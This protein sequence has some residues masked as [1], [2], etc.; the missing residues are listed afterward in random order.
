M[1]IIYI[2]IMALASGTSNSIGVDIFLLKFRP[3]SP[4]FPI[5]AKENLPT[6][7]LFSGTKKLFKLFLDVSDVE[8]EL[9]VVFLE[10]VV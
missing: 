9:L 2:I 10:V 1:I 5:S 4:W 7:K 8:G 6:C 3:N